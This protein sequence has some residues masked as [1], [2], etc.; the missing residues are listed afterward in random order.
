MSSSKPHAL[1]QNEMM[2]S[3]YHD[4]AVLGTR[5][6]LNESTEKLVAM[7]LIP[8][9]STSVRDLEQGG[10]LLPAAD[11][12]AARGLLGFPQVVA[13]FKARAEAMEAAPL[14][15]EDP[16]V[17]LYQPIGNRKARKLHQQ[18]E[19]AFVEFAKTALNCP[20]GVN[21][22]F[23][24]FKRARVFGL[25]YSS[26]A[27]GSYLQHAEVLYPGEEQLEPFYGKINAF[28][29]LS[30]VIEGRLNTFALAHGHWN[31]AGRVHKETKLPTLGLK[32]RQHIVN[33]KQLTGRILLLPS[34]KDQSKVLAVPY[35]FISDS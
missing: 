8:E 18:C 10:I 13:A 34:F 26:V 7:G 32:D 15:R 29:Q 14:L 19:A 23:Q 1:S 12:K 17:L 20:R 24:Y 25:R 30:F 11:L 2:S 5:L 3:Y 31:H 16:N 4:T 21:L 27:G 6:A 33:V 28:C 9:Q 22:K 35:P